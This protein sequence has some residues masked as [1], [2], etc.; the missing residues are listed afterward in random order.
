L[1][2][3]PVPPSSRQ[4]GDPYTINDTLKDIQ[5]TP[6]GAKLLMKA[7]KQNEDTIAAMG[8][9]SAASMMRAMLMEIPLRTLIGFSAEPLPPHYAKMLVDALNG[10]SSPELSRLF[11]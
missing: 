1:Y 3:R 6:I 8:D 7:Q 11:G 2:G 5:N 10:K 9:E 4:S